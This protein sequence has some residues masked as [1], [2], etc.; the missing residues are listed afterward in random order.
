MDSGTL[1]FQSGLTSSGS[2]SLAA[3]ATLELDNGGTLTGAL[4]GSG[5]LLVTGGSTSLSETTSGLAALTV[6]GGAVTIGATGLLGTATALSISDNGILAVSGASGTLA[7]ALSAN[8]GTLSVAGGTNLTLTGPV[9]LGSPAANYQG[10]AGIIGPGTLTTTGTTTIAAYN[11]VSNVPELFLGG[12]ITW[13]NTGTVNDAGFVYL[14]TNSPD[15]VAI[16][17]QAGA[18][19]NLIGGTADLAQYNGGTDTIT[20]AGT[21]SKTGGGTSQINMDVVNTGL[22]TAKAGT[23]VLAGADGSSLAGTVGSSGTGLVLAESNITAGGSLSILDDGTFTSLQLSAVTLTNSGTIADAGKLAFGFGT[24]G[25]TSLVN[26]AGA[27]FDLTSND[28]QISNSGTTSTITITNAGLIAKTGGT[29]LS[30]IAGP[31]V[32]S[33]TIESAAGTLRLAGSS[34]TGTGALKIDAGATLDLAAAPAATQAISFT[35]GAGATLKLEHDVSFKNLGGF[36]AGDRLDI[37]SGTITT[38][39]L[40]G[41]TLTVVAGT[42]T[43]TYASASLAGDAVT[44]T[45]DGAIGSYVNVFR[46]AAATHAPEPLAFGNHHVGDTVSIGLTVSN[47]AA[48]DGY[49]E[50]L[51]ASLS[52]ASAA[53]TASGSLSGLAAGASNSTSLTVGLSTTKAG[54]VS[55]AATLSLLSDGSGVDNRGTTAL[56]SQI[57]NLSGAVYNYAAASLASSTITLANQHVG[58]A[59]SAALSVSNTAATGGYSEALDATFAASTGA[60]NGTGSLSGLAAGSAG[61]GLAV[62]L[63]T[64]GAGALSGTDTLAFVS[65]GTGID[66]LGTTALNT[67]TVTITGAVYNYAAASVANGGTVT[68]AESHV[69]QAVSGL[70][71]V[72][73]SAAAGSYSEALD[74]SLSGG[75]TGFSAT[76]SFA[77][78]AAGSGTS[79]T[80]GAT[81]SAAGAYTGIATLGLVSDGTGIDGL[82]TTTLTGQTVVITG[83]AYA[84]ASAQVTSTTI[85]LGV[86]HTGSVASASLG[87]TNAAAANG[88]SE[89]LDASLSGGSTGV[90]ASGS[91]TGL[92]AG[93]SSS[94]LAIGLSTSS[95]GSYSGTALLSLVSDGAGIDTLGTTTLT[96]QTITVTGTVD[97]YAVATFQDTGGPAATG[98]STNETIN[99]GSATQGG[100]ALSLSLGALNA[101]TG[102]A[103]LLQGSVTTA[104]AAGFA[105]SGFGS[106]SG[107]GAGQSEQ[108]QR[109]VLSTSSAG[110][111]SETV[112]LSSSGT[113]A[114][115]YNGALVTETLTITGTITPSGTTTY[116]LAVGPNTIVGADG[117]D[118]FQAAS[119]ALNSHDSLTGGNGANVLQLTGAGS[120]D[121]GAPKVFANIQ[122]INAHEGQAASGTSA[123]TNQTL[124]LRDGTSETVKVAAGA[125]AAGNSGPETIAIYDGNDTDG[126]V[127]STGVDALYLGAGTDTVTLGG[128]KNS[129]VAGGGTATINGTALQAVASVVGTATGL[130]T[131]NITSAGI[132]ALNAA[133]TYVAV[134]LVAGSRLTLGAMGFITANG[135]AGKETILAGGA[136]QTLI[137]GTT[138]VLTGYTGGSDT[139]LGAS[140]A[141]NGDT[142]GNWT[143]GDMIDITDMN[144]ATLKALTFSGGKLGASDGTHTDAI[145]VKAVGTGTLTVGNFVVLGTDGHGGTLIGWHA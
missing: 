47:T 81:S 125:P 127:L 84:Y 25:T 66:G 21:L 118:I 112:V 48:S 30:T 101:A 94:A 126:F 134:N 69:G 108:S 36:G 18:L 99:L 92:A 107:L 72:T 65:D 121:V 109:V 91:L 19:F 132:V 89:A 133:D 31:I 104:G 110:T 88:Y 105:N 115:G 51:D 5:T 62:G 26:Q 11:T 38:A 52:G 145:T 100:T 106:F 53:L 87:L 97:N 80:V 128:A 4:S 114:S 136:N 12:Q 103:D 49:S 141:L 61:N 73:N 113:N 83:A 15:T 124:F 1:D 67:Q 44:V 60:A 42:T 79:L 86:V 45:P 27:V 50:N 143:T 20:N 63:S 138:D 82:G 129:I 90:L 55:G 119:G 39:T 24:G 98:S 22:I 56:P 93:A 64:A 68:L 111:F 23:L 120:F 139:F 130:T 140:A 46:E 77:G 14:N 75:G 137:G 74:A 123:A 13:V 16:V 40:S 28:A 85:N 71:G 102:L 78:L 33:G 7:A 32:N 116:L 59:D 144:S 3:G 9:T 131:L 43:T 70:L 37:A 8:A 122:T 117:G 41:T 2:I 58:A 76:G 34:L 35:G 142:L 95:S 135:G 96:G 6:T 54:A 17:N 29:G 57:V 10:G